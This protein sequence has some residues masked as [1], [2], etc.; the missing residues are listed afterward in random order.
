VLTDIEATPKGILY[1]RSLTQWIGGMGI[2]VLTVAIFPIL[3]IGGIELFGAE[4]PGPTSDK[5]HPRIQETAKRLWLIYV[6]FTLA[7][8]PILY[9][10]GMGFYDALNH[11]FTIMAT[12]GFSTRND[13]MAAFEHLPAV[14][15]IAILFMVLSGANYTMLYFG[16]KGRWRKVWKNDEFRAYLLVLGLL[17]LVVC[18][19]VKSKT[20]QGWE[21][22]VR[23]GLFQVVSIATT[24]GFVSA[25][26]T[27]WGSSMIM[28]FLLMMFLGGCSGST[29][30]SIKLVRHLVFFKN[31]LLEFKRLLHPRALVPLKLNGQVVPGR[32]LTHIIIFLLLYLLL[33]SL[34]CIVASAMGLDF[35]TAVGAV[36]SSLCNVGPGIGGV[37]PLDNFAWLPEGLKLFLA[38]LMLLGRLEIFTILVLFTPYFWKAN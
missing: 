15:Y 12:G 25:D 21:H 36:A 8:I 11:A 6:G 4:S 13:S 5:V 26:Y 27:A 29:S 2:V 23:D 1:W 31:S 7:L 16:L 17:T 37:G 18:A 33:F 32:I 35:I 30:G 38:F 10:A 24:S 14:Q 3:G 34:G 19:V 22:A 9:L 20:G 28:L